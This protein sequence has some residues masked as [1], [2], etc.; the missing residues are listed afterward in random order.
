MSYIEGYMEISALLADI[1]VRFT[2]F[3]KVERRQAKLGPKLCKK[4]DSGM[5]GYKNKTEVQHVTETQ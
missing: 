1:D 4:M 3:Q 2:Y 5:L